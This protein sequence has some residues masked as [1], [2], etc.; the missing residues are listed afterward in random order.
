[1]TRIIPWL[2]LLLGANVACTPSYTT[3][4]APAPRVLVETFDGLPGR[5][6]EFSPRPEVVCWAWMSAG[7]YAGGIS[8]LQLSTASTP[9][10]R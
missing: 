7:G 6:Y 4:E 9:T 1:M 5:V 10:P 3:A 8:C 2:A